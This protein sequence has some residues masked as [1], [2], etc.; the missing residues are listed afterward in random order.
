MDIVRVLSQEAELVRKIFILIR[1]KEIIFVN[2]LDFYVT[3]LKAHLT[4]PNF[5]ERLAFEKIPDFR[6]L[7]GGILIPKFWDSPCHKQLGH[8]RS[9]N[10]KLIFMLTNF[11]DRQLSK[12][13]HIP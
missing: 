1:F 13:Y 10:R 3:Y 4:L 7:A 8:F 12:R 2:W 5:I 11:I 6:D 9:T